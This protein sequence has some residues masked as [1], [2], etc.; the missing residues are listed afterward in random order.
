M[1]VLFFLNIK[2]VGINLIFFFNPDKQFFFHTF[3]TF[4]IH[5][6]TPPIAGSVAQ[7]IRH[8]SRWLRVRVLPKVLWLLQSAHSGG[9]NLSTCPRSLFCGYYFSATFVEYGYIILDN[10]APSVDSMACW[11]GRWL[12]RPGTAGSS[13]TGDTESFSV[14][15][16]WK[17]QLSSKRYPID[18]SLA[19]NYSEAHRR[20]FG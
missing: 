8:R 7:R 19:R 16:Y 12:P 15:T 20:Y 14:C 10:F 17:I 6:V 3:H 18:S 11:I 13:P 5:N 2:Y 9:F 4:L 1:A